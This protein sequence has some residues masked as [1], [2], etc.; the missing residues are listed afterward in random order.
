VSAF[1]NTIIEVENVNFN[2]FSS[3]DLGMESDILGS[4][5]KSMNFSNI[6]SI[7]KDNLNTPYEETYEYMAKLT[8]L[9]DVFNS[10]YYRE[11]FL[12]RYLTN[13][14]LFAS[15][16]LNTKLTWQQHG[17]CHDHNPYGGRLA[18]PSGHGCGK[19]KLI[20][21]L[22]V[23]HMLCNQK[24]ITRIQAPKLEQ[25]TKLSFGEVVSVVDSMRGSSN[26]NG[27]IEPNKWAFLA[28]FISF[29]AT[30]IYVTGFKT[31]WYIESA[32]AK[33][34]ESNSLSGQH[35]WSYLL[36]LDEAC[37]IE[38]GHI[39]ASLGGLTESRNS[40]IAFSQHANTNSM[41]HHF[42][43]TLSVEN[44]GVWRVNRLSSVESPLVSDGALL[45][46]IATYTE[47][48]RRVRVE[49]LFPLDDAGNL[50]SLQN[51]SQLYNVEDKPWIEAIAWTCRGF[52]TDIAYK[53]VRDSSVTIRYNLA[54]V[55]NELGI[56]KYFVEV[57]DI[58][59]FHKATKLR[60]TDVGKKAVQSMVTEIRDSNGY[61]YDE[62]INAVDASSGGFE[63]SLVMQDEATKSEEPITIHG[64]EWAS[65]DSLSND[66]RNQYINERAK[67]YMKLR[68]TIQD[69]RFIVSCP[70]YKTRVLREMEN[71]P[72]LMDSK[73]RYQIASKKDMNSAS[74]DILDCFAEI[75]IIPY[76]DSTE[77]NAP[78]LNDKMEIEEIKKLME[79]VAK[80]REESEGLEE[81]SLSVVTIAH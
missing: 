66:E 25:I 14:P 4:Y 75:F 15:E 58:E 55:S 70:K 9:D 77:Q 64:L 73:F 39:V 31:Q 71:I 59:I 26:I 11:Y 8:S 81:S 35:G 5:E 16:V 49:G 22:C 7:R 24:S 56:T 62:Y 48:E 74:P 33:R 54:S 36:I 29:T 76:L 63:T 34:G 41:F 42:V 3:Y 60:P 17:I 43:T 52:T 21:V 44:G 37:G 78:L 30:L 65:S 80:T 12:K 32:V 68:E 2:P 18:V 23:H 46:F 1:L 67:G 27:I 79:R 45:N 19:T 10:Y 28:N 61:I 69:G 40:C 38:D 51:M 50:F 13:I 20:G 57:T 47:D 6:N 53:G 72:L